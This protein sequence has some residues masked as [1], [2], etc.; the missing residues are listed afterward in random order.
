MTLQL[1]PELERKLE[2]LATEM[3]RSPS[4]LAQEAIDHYLQSADTFAF[5]VREAEEEA[6]REGWLSS[7]QV[8]ERLEQRF[9]KTA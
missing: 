5:E 8:K 6:D 2:Q 7:E 3:H 1:T 4:E 9:R